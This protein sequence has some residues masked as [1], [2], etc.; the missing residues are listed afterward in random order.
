[1]CWFL[2]Q[3]SWRHANVPKEKSSFGAISV[4]V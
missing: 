1:M 4:S 2:F 3:N